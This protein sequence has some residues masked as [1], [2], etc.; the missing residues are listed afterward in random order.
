MSCVEPWQ[1]ISLTYI[2]EMLTQSDQALVSLKPHP[3]IHSTRMCITFL[4][5]ICITGMCI[6]FLHY[7]C[8][9]FLHVHLVLWIQGCGFSETNQAS[10]G[11]GG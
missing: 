10:G 9:T 6:T 8:I 1:S 4:H 3:W 5:Y 11:A 7:I 2:K